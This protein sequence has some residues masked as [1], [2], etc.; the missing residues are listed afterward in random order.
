MVT[1]SKCLVFYLALSS[2]EPNYNTSHPVLQFATGYNLR[3]KGPEIRA[4]RALG[5]VSRLLVSV[6]WS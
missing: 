6:P 3:R 2:R 5:L 1:N 4:F